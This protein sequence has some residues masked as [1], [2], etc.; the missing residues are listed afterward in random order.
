VASYESFRL[1]IPVKGGSSPDE[2]LVAHSFST[3][4][5]ST[6]GDTKTEPNQML[7]RLGLFADWEESF[8]AVELR[9]VEL[10]NPVN[11]SKDVCSTTERIAI[12]AN[13]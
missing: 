9:G 8:G 2:F 1:I 10:A 12:L 7:F 6:N 5:I 11:T 13:C 3:D 4:R